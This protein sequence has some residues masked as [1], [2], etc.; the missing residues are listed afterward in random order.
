MIINGIPGDSLS[1]SDR[2]LMYGDGVFRTLRIRHNKPTHWQP[3]YSKLQ[4]D[5][6]A[7]GIKCPP[8]QILAEDIEQLIRQHSEFTTD[9]VAKII[10]TR[11]YATRGYAPAAN[12]QLSRILS[13][14]PMP[15]YPLNYASAG[16]RLHLCK[17]RLGH[18]PRLAGIKHLNRLENVLA[19]AE[20][21][22]ENIAEGI[23]LDEDN[24]IIEGTRSNLFLVRN[25]KLYTPDLSRCGVAGL[26]RDRVIDYAR[27]Q[28]IVCKITELTMDDLVSAD[29]IFLVNSVVGLWP[30]R[31]LPGFSCKQFPFSLQIQE[32]LNNENN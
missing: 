26:Q 2:G 3:H 14:S 13:F 8:I 29:E 21:N 1:A 23:M 31:E 32:W 7:I 19:A 9:G 27:Q 30:V 15:A 22:D 28:R 25:G 11:G 20:W 5:C 6:T 17:F 10:I 4:H 24:L 16:V 18:Q 12:P